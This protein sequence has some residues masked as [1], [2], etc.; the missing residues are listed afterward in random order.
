MFV[1]QKTFDALLAGPQEGKENSIYTYGVDAYYKE[2]SVNVLAT[3]EQSENGRYSSIT[4][5]ENE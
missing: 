1:T 5:A 3:M 2:Q 4:I